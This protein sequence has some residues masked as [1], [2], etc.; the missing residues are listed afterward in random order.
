MAETQSRKWLVL[1]ILCAAQF[2]VVLDVSIVNV[3]SAVNTAW[4]S[5]L[6]AESCCG[7]LNAYTLLFGGIP[8]ARRTGRRQSGASPCLHRRRLSLLCCITVLRAGY[9]LWM[10]GDRR[11]VQGLGAAVGGYLARPLFRY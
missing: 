1:V 6:R 3:A 7:F 2:M 9:K 11:G 10:A 5:L 4:S 8:H